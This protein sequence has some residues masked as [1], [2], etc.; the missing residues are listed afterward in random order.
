MLQARPQ[1]ADWKPWVAGLE[2][3]EGRT[4]SPAAGSRNSHHGGAYAAAVADIE[5]NKKT[6]K[7]TVKHVYAAQ[8]S[9]LSMNPSLSRTR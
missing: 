2:A 4:S 1:A 9:G 6:G 8:D 3:S 7:I 5:V